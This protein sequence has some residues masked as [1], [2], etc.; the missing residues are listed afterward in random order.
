MLVIASPSPFVNPLPFVSPLPVV[1][2]F[3]GISG[4]DGLLVLVSFTKPLSILNFVD[5]PG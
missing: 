4:A 1:K 3:E 2:A 5:S